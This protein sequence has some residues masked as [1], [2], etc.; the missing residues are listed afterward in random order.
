MTA[1]V[2]HVQYSLNIH[3]NTFPERIIHLLFVF[4]F[5]VVAVSSSVL[6]MTAI[7]VE[8]FFAIV[9][10]LK[11]RMPPWLTGIVVSLNWFLAVGIAS[12]HL[13][14][15]VQYEYYWADRHQVWCDENWPRVYTDAK[16]HTKSPGKTIYYTVEGI[17]MYFVPIVVMVVAYSLILV[18]MVRRKHPGLTLTTVTPA[19]E[20]SRKKVYVSFL[21]S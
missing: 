3:D 15:R 10:P 2:D 5:V 16:C 7:S 21:E 4:L 14:V 18:K 13:F 20:R 1:Q 11:P 8:R 19:Q 6:N 17:V 9:Y 12:P